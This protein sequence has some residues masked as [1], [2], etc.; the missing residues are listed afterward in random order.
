[1][2]GKCMIVLIMSL[3]FAGVVLADYVYEPDKL[4]SWQGAIEPIRCDSGSGEYCG[5]VSGIAKQDVNTIFKPNQTYYLSFMA[6]S[7]DNSLLTAALFG[8]QQTRQISPAWTSY[9]FTFKTPLDYNGYA[10]L[11]I[12]ATGNVLIDA[13]KLEEAYK[14]KST[15]YNEPSTGEMTAYPLGCCPEDY[16]WNGFKCVKGEN[17]FS[18]STWDNNNDAF[19]FDS[20]MYDE[21]GIDGYLCVEGDWNP[22][23]Y[24]EQWFEQ[25]I[26]YC[27]SDFDCWDG[28]KCVVNGNYSGDYWC[29]NGNWTSRTKYIAL[30]MMDVVGERD[31]FT[32]FCDNYKNSLNSLGYTVRG[33]PVEQYLTGSVDLG[34]GLS[35]NLEQGLVNNFCALNFFD[36]HDVVVLGAALNQPI[37]SQQLNMLDV[38]NVLDCRPAYDDQVEKDDGQ[39][40]SCDS[41]GRLWYNYKTNSIIY[42]KTGIKL[43]EISFFDHFFIHPIRTFV[44]LIVNIFRPTYKPVVGGLVGEAQEVQYAFA[45]QGPKLFNRIYA[46]VLGS[47]NIIGTIEQINIDDSIMIVNYN[48][49]ENICKATEK[50][51]ARLSGTGATGLN[52]NQTDDI[53]YIVVSRDLDAMNQW[54]DA[55]AKIR[56]N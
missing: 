6:K 39:F 10:T 44:D 23:Y 4:T 53:N 52:C 30:Q 33:I 26:G 42:S 48:N 43:G 47:K 37:D 54:L 16:C 8:L 2:F 34:G 1:M 46:N 21:E 40:H 15:L 27:T 49:V 45:L 31:N 24:K 20:W 55:T 12:G 9:I 17:V 51:N 38:F 13:I 14:P 56:L 19:T 11:E 7:T 32:M 18:K 35:G 36:N 28:Q 3:F 5:L 22:A 25:T 50:Y 29:E 41:L